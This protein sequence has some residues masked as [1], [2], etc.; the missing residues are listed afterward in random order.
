MKFT[1]MS[2]LLLTCLMSL[3][4]NAADKTTK[5]QTRA[6]QNAGVPAGESATSY[7]AGTSV[8]VGVSAV[9]ALA[10]LALATQSNDGG[11]STGTS[12]TTSTTGR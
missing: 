11:S 7:A 10:A 9:S 1:A 3:S 5:Q 6:A 8:V 12:T 2:T 4:V